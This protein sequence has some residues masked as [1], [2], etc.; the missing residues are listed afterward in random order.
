MRVRCSVLYGG[1]CSISTPRG[2]HSGRIDPES[3]DVEELLKDLRSLTEIALLD[4]LQ[5]SL[6]M[7]SLVFGEL[8]VTHHLPHS[9]EGRRARLRCRKA[10]GVRWAAVAGRRVHV[11]ALAFR[12]ALERPSAPRRRDVGVRN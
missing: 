12:T 3:L 6:R 2:C 10:R 8:L 1:P 5:D 11:V 7:H 9:L 4:E